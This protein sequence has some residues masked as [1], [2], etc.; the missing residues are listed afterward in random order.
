[1]RYAAVCYTMEIKFRYVY[2]CYI[3]N[4]LCHAIKLGN[5][6]PPK[7]KGAVCAYG[8]M[9][10]DLY[11]D[12]LI[13][14]GIKVKLYTQTEEGEFQSTSLALEVGKSVASCAIGDFNGDA[15]PDILVITNTKEHYKAVVFICTGISG[16]DCSPFQ[17]D[18]EFLD[19]PGVIDVNGDGKSDLVGFAKDDQKFI[20]RLGTEKNGVFAKC[21]ESFEA[22]KQPGFLKGFPISFVDVTGDLSAEVIFAM[23]NG[24]NLV[25]DV[26]K[27]SSKNAWKR[28]VELI[29]ELKIEEG[30]YFGVPLFA[31]FDADGSMDIAVP[32]CAD[33][34]C[35]RVDSIWIWTNNHWLP[36][37]I[38]LSNNVASS[39][40]QLSV[41]FRVGDF[42][43]DGYPDLL[44]LVICEGQPT[45]MILEN[46]ECTSC[47]NNET[48]Q[49]TL[50]TT[51]RLIQP[52]GV[53]LGKIRMASFFDLMEDGTLD[54]L[55]EYVDVKDHRKKETTIDFIQYSDYG[56]TTFLKV[57]VFSSCTKNC[58]SEKIKIGSGIAWH[59]ACVSYNMSVSRKLEQR[60][61]QCQMPQTTHRT[62]YSPFTLFGLGRSPNFVDY[63]RI[64]S[65]RPVDASQHYGLKQLVPNSRVIVV[66]PK[67]GASYWQSRLYVTPSSLIIQSLI[68]LI[69]VC[70]SLLLIIAV[71]HI[72]ERRIDK[73]ERQAQSHRFHFD[74]M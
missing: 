62:F 9:N 22:D 18:E 41:V 52:S 63:V 66:P 20:C 72:R 57:E 73:Q 3:L 6:S 1:M 17:L 44:A 14:D 10:R 69:S 32:V 59:G 60:G 42:T 48:R 55:L 21:E 11:T 54:V 40:G 16:S 51:P 68:V 47:M 23:R 37:T 49:F 4:T 36:S 13:H 58:G 2:V 29:K 24:S 25:L 46:T 56:D 70:S 12:L 34:P 27:R 15:L 53:S 26:W 28:S 61:T 38:S 35:T 74:A 71:L 67:N 64:G 5:P 31:D 33:A 43:L 39:T 65:P 8:D 7:L 50:R 45:P 19:E 30:K